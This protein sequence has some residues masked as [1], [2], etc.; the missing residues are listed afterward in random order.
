MKEPHKANIFH[1]PYA[2]IPKIVCP[3]FL[4]LFSKSFCCVS[5]YFDCVCFN[6]M[7]NSMTFFWMST[8]VELGA[9]HTIKKIFAG[10][11][12]CRSGLEVD[13]KT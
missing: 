9:W 8:C 10:R 2:D 5:T 12:L 11:I 6:S 13:L 3:C 1:G 7:Y 4:M